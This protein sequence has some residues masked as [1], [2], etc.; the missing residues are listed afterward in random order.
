MKAYADNPGPGQAMGL[1]FLN[2]AGALLMAFAIYLA[3][4]LIIAAGVSIGNAIKSIPGVV[5]AIAPPMRGQF[6]R[7]IANAAMALLQ[8]IFAI[9]F[10]VGYVMVVEDLF[11]ADESNLIRTVFFVDI[12]L[13]TALLLYRRA[14]KGMKRMSDNLATILAKR[15]NAAP[16]ASV[17]QRPP[18]RATS[19]RWPPTDATCTRRKGRGEGGRST[20]EEVR[21]CR[22]NDRK[23]RSRRHVDR[24]N[25]RG[26]CSAGCRTGPLLDG[27]ASEEQGRLDRR[28]RQLPEV[29]LR[30]G[31][32]P[33]QSWNRRYERC[34]RRCP[35]STVENGGVGQGRHQAPHRGRPVMAGRPPWPGPCLGHDNQWSGRSPIPRIHHHIWGAGDVADYTEPHPATSQTCLS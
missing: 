5:L 8:M 27:E 28:S 12:F 23:G 30:R 31:P 13:V 17:A 2:F 25:R 34:C 3:G 6:W 22:G 10:L 29:H 24:S 7:T 15:P 11:A 19:L 14:V 33:D 4:R 9:V 35:E 21:H 20:S 1:F 18:Q 16:T 26:G 32:C